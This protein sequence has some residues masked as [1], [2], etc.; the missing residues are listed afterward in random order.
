VQADPDAG[1]R[2][3][4]FE[5]AV[6][7]NIIFWLGALSVFQLSGQKISSTGQVLPYIA[8][9]AA[10]QR[11]ESE[12]ASH[13]ENLDLAGQLLDY[14]LRHWQQPDVHAARLRLILWTTAN[15]PDIQLAGRHDPRGL[16]VNPDDRQDYAQV[17][18]AWLDQVSRN[19]G[20][21]KVLANAARCLRLTDRETAANWLK[22]AMKLD[23]RGGFFVSDLGDL[24]A[25]AISGISGMNPWEG[26][27]SVD[28]GET[29]SDFARLARVEAGTES[30]LA[31]RTGWALHQV[32]DAL[33]EAKIIAPD[34]DPIAEKLLIQ[35]ADLDYP[36]PGH[37]IFLVS[38]YRDQQRKASNRVMPKW[39]TV[40]VSGEE[41]AIRLVEGSKQISYTA[42][43]FHSAVTVP[44]RITIGIDGHVWKA[45]A[46]GAP[47]IAGPVAAAS[48]S[49]WTYQPLR[50]G[51]EPVQVSTVVQVTV[52]PFVPQ[53]P[54]SPLH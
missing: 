8:D 24:Y 15:H 26:P 21:A 38:F 23:S 32:S 37:S 7:C 53:T 43:D 28:A 3:L 29:Q 52:E 39:R 9:Q 4:P 54:L 10:A 5:E 18:T 50:I 31:A 2:G 35:A 27:T 45:E 11:A 47:Q 12:L 1:C 46:L 44:V 42:N 36:Q 34:Y 33:R 22:Q 51:G 19:S 20:S 17:R 48:T 40:E 16:L 25:D 13:P 30:E 41:Q 14:Y 49:M 6:K